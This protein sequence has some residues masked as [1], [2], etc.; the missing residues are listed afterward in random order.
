MEVPS[1]Q[2]HAGCRQ[3]REGRGWSVTNSRQKG[4]RGERYVAAMLTRLGYPAT[5]AARIGVRGGEDISCPSLFG[6]VHFECKFTETIGLDTMELLRAVEQSANARP[7]PDVRPCVIWKNN[8]GPICLT[9]QVDDSQ[10]W[11]TIAGE[12]DIRRWLEHVAPG[13]RINTKEGA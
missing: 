1:E 3:R 4:A 2:S 13:K 7:G 10:V 5:R 9:Y 12:G 6:I 8:R 11:P